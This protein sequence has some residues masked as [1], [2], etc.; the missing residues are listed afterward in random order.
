MNQVGLK[1]RWMDDYDSADILVLYVLGK[2][3]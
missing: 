2:I 1:L 3:N